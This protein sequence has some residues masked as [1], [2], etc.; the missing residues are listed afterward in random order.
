VLVVAGLCK[1]AFADGTYPAWL[2][3]IATLAAFLAT[4]IAVRYANGAY[5]L[6]ELREQ[7][8]VGARDRAQA[9]LVAAWAE[10]RPRPGKPSFPDIGCWVRNASVVPVTNVV[11]QPEI[12]LETSPRTGSQGIDLIPPAKD[13]QL[14]RFAEVTFEQD[15]FG[16]LT[17]AARSR[18]GSTSPMPAGVGGNARHVAS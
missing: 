7:R 3:A 15:L 16:A 8:W 5:Q 12:Q 4:A 9:S 1:L 17:R 10:I 14:V 11:V 6:E 2:E 13:R 18:S